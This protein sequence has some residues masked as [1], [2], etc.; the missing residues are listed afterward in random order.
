MKG[1]MLKSSFNRNKIIYILLIILILVFSAF[2]F[3]KNNNFKADILTQDKRCIRTK[4]DW[5]DHGVPKTITVK[6]FT[7]NITVT[8]DRTDHEE[9]FTQN[10]DNKK[11]DIL[12][13]IDVSGSMTDNQTMLAN[14]IGSFINQFTSNDLHYR[15]AVTTTETMNKPSG[16]RDQTTDA[17]HGDFQKR[18]TAPYVIDSL[19]LTKQQIISYF[20]AN[21]VLGVKILSHREKGLDSA[22]LALTKTQSALYPKNQGFLRPEAK[23]AIVVVTDENDQSY[24]YSTQNYLERIYG[25]KA[26]HK[27]VVTIYAI[28]DVLKNNQSAFDPYTAK[29]N[30]AL[31]YLD[32]RNTYGCGRYKK[33]ASETGGFVSEITYTDWGDK[34]Q[35]IGRNIATLANSFYLDRQPVLSTVQVSVKEVGDLEYQI[36]PKHDQ[37]GWRYNDI[38]NAIVFGGNYVPPS[39]ASIR[40]VYQYEN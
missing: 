35:E 38:K 23:L 26:N 6:E 9:I 13:L 3:F 8:E 24:L 28:C 11:V 27:E 32:D 17:A 4:V 15:M 2:L 33:A 39:G 20:Q 14:N 30:P 7:S 10:D 5:T 25:F 40:V 18:G 37:Q 1:C 21:I 29:I 36:I 19:L 22:H 16:Y 31:Y 34:L 12:W